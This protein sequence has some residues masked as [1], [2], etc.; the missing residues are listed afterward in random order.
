MV[1][2]SLRDLVD[3]PYACLVNLI[4]TLGMTVIKQDSLRNLCAD[5]LGKHSEYFYRYKLWNT[6][7]DSMKCKKDLDIAHITDLQTQGYINYCIEEKFN[8]TIP[9]YDYK[10]WFQSTSEITKMIDKISFAN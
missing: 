9:P 5:W 8:I 10:T 7:E 6:I 2:L 3:T 1:N 4:T